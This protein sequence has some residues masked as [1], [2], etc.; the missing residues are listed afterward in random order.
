LATDRKSM[1]L[2]QYMTK[3]ICCWI[4][5]C[6]IGVRP[7]CG[8]AE[9]VEEA[10]SLLQLSKSVH[11]SLYASS[12]VLKNTTEQK[13][14][15]FGL[16][17]SPGAQYKER[18]A[19]IDETW[20]KE[21]SPQ[22]L[23]V[24]NGN[25]SIP[26]ITSK[27]TQLCPDKQNPGNLCKRATLVATGFEM[28]VDWLVV[29]N[30]DHYVFPRHWEELL[31]NYNSSD[32]ILLGD[33]GCGNHTF[34]Q[35]HKNGLCGGWGYAI[36]SG[37]L[38]AMVGKYQE[39]PSQ[40]YIMETVIAAI[41]NKSPWGDQIISCVARRSD[42]KELTIPKTYFPVA[43]KTHDYS[44]RRDM[45]KSPEHK[46]LIF[47]FVDPEE[48]REIDKMTKVAEQARLMG[49]MEPEGTSPSQKI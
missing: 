21:L 31:E 10:I 20:G 42:V 24:I 38:Q 25:S 12:T 40:S 26:N 43:E 47:N 36:S 4:Y 8:E 48:M 41:E 11:S 28:K 14:V 23:L 3:F 15:V 1:A 17:I 44:V 18:M 45:I 13:K 19:A 32:K 9:E 5:L 16:F 2:L 29:L 33:H 34:C 22:Q 7:V 37:A 6:I 46:P 27:T 35:D 39:H 49:L 30:D